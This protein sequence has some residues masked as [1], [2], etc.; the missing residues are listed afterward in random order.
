MRINNK[1]ML[2]IISSAVIVSSAYISTAPQPVSAAVSV[3]SAKSMV[4]KAESAAYRL[5]TLYTTIGRYHVITTELTTA[6]SL[7]ASA[8][9]AVNSLPSSSTKT[10]LQ[11]RL[12]KVK[13][14]IDRATNFNNALYAAS[15]VHK[16]IEYTKTILAKDTYNRNQLKAEFDKNLGLIKAMETAL[17]KIYSSDVRRNLINKYQY[18]YHFSEEL[19]RILHDTQPPRVLDVTETKYNIIN[20]VVSDVA[21]VSM[22]SAMNKNKYKINGNALPSNSIIKVVNSGKHQST[23][24]ISLQQGTISETKKHSLSITGLK[25]K[26]GMDASPSN[27]EV[28]LTDNVSP[29]LKEAIINQAN[30]TQLIFSYGE[31]LATS[32][33]PADVMIKLYERVIPT[34]EIRVTPE[35]NEAGQPTGRDL[36]S[37]A[38]SEYWQAD[39]PVQYY[40]EMDGESGYS[41]RDLNLGFWN[42]F[43]NRHNLSAGTNASTVSVDKSPNRNLLK[44]NITLNIK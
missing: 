33:K 22:A 7:Y 18:M 25:D 27:H 32:I 29:E 35:L 20:I 17:S 10:D 41:E 42:S 26:Y 38:T 3:S 34:S 36:V 28:A 39:S 30:P 43:A 19:D 44:P 16:H 8:L 12:Q 9:K 40:V 14:Y 6:K 23:I 2:S 4:S 37:I 5:H 31:P 21:G 15:N 1:K 13:V 24:Q 11:K